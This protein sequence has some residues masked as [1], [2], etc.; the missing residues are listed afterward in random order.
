MLRNSRPPYIS[1]ASITILL[2][3]LT[4]TPRK[5]RPFIQKLRRIILR[6]CRIH[7]RISSRNLLMEYALHMFI[8]PALDPSAD[9]SIVWTLGYCECTINA[10]YPFP[11]YDANERVDTRLMSTG[12]LLFKRM[13]VAFSPYGITL[14]FAS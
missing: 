11:S 6:W 2:V 4:P 10:S 13:L 3:P 14:I 5:I 9:L 1:L 8:P 12:R 7:R